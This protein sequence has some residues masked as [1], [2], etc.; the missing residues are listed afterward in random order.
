MGPDDA[1]GGVQYRFL[2][3]PRV[4]PDHESWKDTGLTVSGPKAGDDDASAYH[5][6]RGQALAVPR[7]VTDGP[8]FLG[9]RAIRL[10]DRLEP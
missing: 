10:D 8:T 2:F 5:P 7:A 4:S 1:T 9:G 3:P 6:A